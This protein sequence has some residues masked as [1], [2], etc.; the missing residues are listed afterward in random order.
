MESEALASRILELG[1]AGAKFL[2]PVIIEVPHFASLRNKERE[3]I[4]LR[5]DDGSTWKEHKLDASEEAVQEVLNESFPG[6]ELR[7]LED[8]HTSRIVRIL[9]VDFPQYFAV[10]SRLRQEIHA[11]GPEGGV[12]SSSAVPLVQ[13]LFPPDALTKRIKV[14]LQ[15]FS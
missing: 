9:T 4:I 3:L 10:V 15:V 14:G 12:V 11:V 7:Q 1:P 5:S 2:G 8:L 6:E 13:A